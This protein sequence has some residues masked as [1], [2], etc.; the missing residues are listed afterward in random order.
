MKIFVISKKTLMLAL[1][2]LLVVIAA[3][4]FALT[5]IGGKSEA[6]DGGDP[7]VGTSGNTLGNASSNVSGN[8]SSGNHGNVVEQYELD[9]LAGLMKELPVYSVSR[10]DKKIALTIDAAWDDDKTDFILETLQRYNIKATFFLCGF[11]AKDYPEKVKLIHEQGHVIGNHSMTHPHM[12]SQS[13]AQILNELKSYDDLLES[14]IGTRSTLFRAPYGEYNDNV[15]TTVRSAGYEVIQWD[16]DTV[17]WK[18]ER[19][20]QTILDTVFSKLKDGSIIL[21]HNN[22]YKIE[23]YLPT[24]IETAL[25]QGYEFVTVS[26]LLHSG[27]TIIDVNGVQKPAE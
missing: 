12:N 1:G 2:A 25:E 13:S 20:A 8:V 21:C 3:I 9:V 7:S 16:V 6:P 11:W 10:E 14:I 4:I 23:Q 19:S 5:S 22:G 17:D 24:L 18:E 27:S 26:E 15:I